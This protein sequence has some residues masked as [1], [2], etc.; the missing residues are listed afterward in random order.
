MNI[1]ELFE[2]AERGPLTYEQFESLAKANDTKFADLSEGKYVSKSKY[3]SDIRAKDAAM[4]TLNGQIESL[5]N[6]IATRDADLVSLQSQLTEAGQDATK[7]ADLT[8]QLSSL[9]S[10]YDADM[11][12]YQDKMAQQ[13]Y[14]FAV[15]E[16]ANT[17]QF[18][19]QRAKRDFT[20]TMIAKQLQME[21]GKIIGGDD[22]V[23]M[24]SADN[25]DAFVVPKAEPEVVE[26]PK[27][28][29]VV[30]T[31]TATATGT[32]DVN[33]DT[34]FHFNFTGVRAHK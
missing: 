5:N 21:G 8:S 2:K 16:F 19:S 4:E 15:K 32:S 33:T 17:K 29:V 10:K 6:T 18:T 9:Q 14:E 27:P 12:S 31:I 24:Y 1:K 30:P 11:K 3:D 23:A 22:F 13:S 34:G 28:E 25:A 26:P 20:Q 7:L